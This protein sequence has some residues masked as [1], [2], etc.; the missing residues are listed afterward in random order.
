M[1]P[2][3]TCSKQRASDDHLPTASGRYHMVRIEGMAGLLYMFTPILVRSSSWLLCSCHQPTSRS[4]QDLN[5]YLSISMR[6]SEKASLLADSPSLVL[7]LVQEVLLAQVHA[8]V[9]HYHCKWYAPRPALQS[10]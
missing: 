9:R 10:H 3:C 8:V 2:L 7:R 6:T 1:A 5:A 4:V